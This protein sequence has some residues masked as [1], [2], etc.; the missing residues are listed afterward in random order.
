[1]SSILGCFLFC[2]YF[3]LEMLT[4]VV[5]WA[6][7]KEK[8]VCNLT[9][10]WIV[11]FLENS[12]MILTLFLFFNCQII[13][14]IVSLIKPIK[15]VRCFYIKLLNHFK[16]IAT[17]NAD[18]KIEVIYKITTFDSNCN[19]CFFILFWVV[20]VTLRFHLCWI[21]LNV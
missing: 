18:L 1:M 16:A 7:W 5:D 11:Y 4:M 12:A 14:K 15:T 6:M 8:Q 3:L 10:G 2:F 17:V 21:D 20:P 13:I 9:V 19:K